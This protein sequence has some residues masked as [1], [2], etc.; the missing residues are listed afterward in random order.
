MLRVAQHSRSTLTGKALPS[1]LAALQNFLAIFL[2]SYFQCAYKSAI[3]LR[4]LIFE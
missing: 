2:A 4:F 1:R 3:V